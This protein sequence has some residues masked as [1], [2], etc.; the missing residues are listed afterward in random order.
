MRSGC[1][2]KMKELKEKAKEKAKKHAAKAKQN[3]KKLRQELS[4]AMNTAIIAAFGFLMA[5]VWRDVIKAWVDKIAETSPV[6]GQLVSALI[7][8]LICVIGIIVVARI[9]K[10]KKD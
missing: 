8:T 4:K 7:V 1:E 5:L 2:I 3:A 10:V 9:F 6:Q